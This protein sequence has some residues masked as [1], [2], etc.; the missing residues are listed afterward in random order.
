MVCV[1]CVPVCVHWRMYGCV[2]VRACPRACLFI[3][4]SLSDSQPAC[5]SNLVPTYFSVLLSPA[6]PL[7]S[8]A[9]ADFTE[10]N[11]NQRR[12]SRRTLSLSLPTRTVHVNPAFGLDD[13]PTTAT[14]VVSARLRSTRTDDNNCSPSPLPARLR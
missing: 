5:P 9:G 7:S 6:T 1:K 4:L 2:C 14:A 10:H 12:T 3:C 13:E 11:I 8:Q